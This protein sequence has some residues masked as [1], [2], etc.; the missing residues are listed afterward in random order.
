MR[1]VIGVD[2]LG[3]IWEGLFLIFLYARAGSASKEHSGC[4]YE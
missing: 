3:G 1:L 2:L 4:L